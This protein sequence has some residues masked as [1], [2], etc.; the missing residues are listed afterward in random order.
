MMHA[1]GIRQVPREALAGL[2]FVERQPCVAQAAVDAQDD[3]PA[4]VLDQLDAADVAPPVRDQELLVEGAGGDVALVE[5]LPAIEPGAR[6]ALDGQIS[7]RIDAVIGADVVDLCLRRR[8]G[9]RV[10]VHDALLRQVDRVQMD[11]PGVHRFLE[12]PDGAL[13]T[14]RTLRRPVEARNDVVEVVVIH[15]GAASDRKDVG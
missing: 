11:G 1:Q 8:P 14:A 12:C 2:L 15:H 3:D 7:A 4:A 10:G 9:G 5:T 13:P 6:L